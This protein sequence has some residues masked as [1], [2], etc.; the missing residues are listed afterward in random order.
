[1]KAAFIVFAICPL[2]LLGIVLSWQSYIVQI[3]QAFKHQHEISSRAQER[4]MDYFRAVEDE[5]TMIARINNLLGLDMVNGYKILSRIRSYDTRLHNDVYNELILLDGQGRERVR[6]SRTRVYT[7]DDLGDMSGAEVFRSPMNTGKIQYG[8]VSFDKFTGEPSIVMGLPLIDVRSALPNGVLV[9]EVRLKNIW[10][11]VANLQIGEAGSAYLLD[12][13]GKLIAHKNPSLVLKGT[14]FNVS[15]GEVIRKGSAGAGVLTDTKAIS[16]G[17]RKIYLVTERPV[18]E[19]LS[20]TFRILSSIGLLLVVAFAGAVTFGLMVTH[21][22]IEPIE[23]LADTARA[24]VDGDLSRRA[25]PGANDEIGLL[26]NSFNTM[27]AQLIETIDSIN[28]EKVKSEAIIAGIGDPLSIVDTN[29][30]VLY[31]NTIHKE[32]MGEHVGEYCYQAYEQREQV[33]DICPMAMAF[34]DGKLHK[35]ERTGLTDRGLIYV[36]VTASPVMDAAGRIIAGIEIGRDITKRKLA[37]KELAAEKERLAVTLASIGDAVI[38]TDTGG[39][40]VLMNKVAEN[41]TG[42]S[43]Q[44]A[45]GSPLSDVLCIVNEK[46]RVRCENPMDKIFKIGPVAGLADNMVL[47]SRNGT[48][49]VIA[50][51]GAPIMGE[52]NEIMGTV[53]VFRDITERRKIEEELLTARKLEAVGILSAGIAHEINNPLTNASLRIQII[54]QELEENNQVGDFWYKLEAIEKNVDKASIIAK[55]LLDFSRQ[56]ELEFIPVNINSTVRSAL[57]S[58]EHKLANINVY[59]DLAELPEI[60][61]DP[62][63]LEQVF[64]NILN[65]AV[66]AM[67]CGG[68][69]DISTSCSDDYVNVKISDTGSGI[70]EQHIARIF[71]PFFTTKEVGAGT[72]L[73]LSICYGI[74]MQ[75]SGSID[76]SNMEKKGTIVTVKLPVRA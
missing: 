75:H 10:N 14:Y 42:W 28:N 59:P 62:V 7:R 36:D 38:A 72:G 51:S 52:N 57:Q 44:E 19:A 56:R 61:G 70:P 17:N 69:V 74:V 2:L 40:V 76:I 1:M 4:I 68:N 41:L 49:R 35:A 37:E 55:E 27:A 50:D 64:I 25:T 45:V 48:E 32:L 9:A 33:C 73:G 39:V 54:K 53:L 46:S 13:T 15:E 20:L 12:E 21:K 31:Q 66:E 60:L 34:A 63:K 43:Q 71:D 5:L 29:F 16:L 22:I 23:S 3:D 8:V 47:I 6:V 24:I 67:S 30:K 65:N 58:I 18:S 26:A 11:L